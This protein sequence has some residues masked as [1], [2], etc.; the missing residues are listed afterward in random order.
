MNAAS[1]QHK[2]NDNPQGQSR[3]LATSR[4]ASA[5]RRQRADINRKLPID[6]N[7]SAS[8]H[9]LNVVSHGQPMGALRSAQLRSPVLRSGVSPVP[10][11][12]P[13]SRSLAPARSLRMPSALRASRAS[14]SI[15]CRERWV[16]SWLTTMTVF[17]PRCDFSRRRTIRGFLFT[18][19]VEDSPV[20][21]ANPPAKREKGRLQRL[22]RNR[23][24]E[25]SCSWIGASRSVIFG[26]RSKGLSTCKL[27]WRLTTPPLRRR[28]CERWHRGSSCAG[29]GT[30]A[31][32]RRIR[33]AR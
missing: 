32:L 15:S 24:R 26:I 8:W 11:G 3:T 31:W 16:G 23:N 2:D 22:L 33:R 5:Y 25:S 28:A 14:L 21:R 13:G 9:Y 29:A 1:N 6:S 4:H 20:P 12:R 10:L 30:S 19:E 18:S 17:P 7:I 27:P